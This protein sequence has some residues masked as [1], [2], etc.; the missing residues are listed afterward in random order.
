M[1]GQP[2]GILML[3]DRSVLSPEVAEHALQCFSQPERCGPRARARRKMHASCLL[4]VGDGEDA[5]CRATAWAWLGGMGCYSVCST[6]L[7][8]L[9]D[10]HTQP[11]ASIVTA[12]RARHM[13]AAVLQ[14]NSLTWPLSLDRS[15][16]VNVQDD[17]IMKGRPTPNAHPGQAQS[18]LWLHRRLEGKKRRGNGRSRNKVRRS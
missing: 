15:V 17:S 8:P 5:S 1:A 9:H 14:D 2:Q 12:T 3:P 11:H 13:A 10:P 6:R 16:L 18:R 4:H 7:S